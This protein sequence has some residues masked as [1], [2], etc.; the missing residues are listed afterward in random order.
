MSNLLDPRYN[1]VKCGLTPNNSIRDG[2]APYSLSADKK[3]PV[4]EMQKNRL[5]REDDEQVRLMA[6]TYGLHSVIRLKMERTICGSSRRHPG[7]DSSLLGLATV[8]DLDDRLEFEDI[9]NVETPDDPQHK[10]TMHDIMERR[11]G[12]L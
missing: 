10:K 8:M 5:R 12:L 11:M 1:A 9:L 6:A 2:L 4:E 3:H 7:I